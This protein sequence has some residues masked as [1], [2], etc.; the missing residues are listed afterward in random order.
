MY[1]I[2]NKNLRDCSPPFGATIK[3]LA[4]GM[5]LFLLLTFVGVIQASGSVLSQNN[6]VNL[7]LQ[8]AS[9]YD[10][11]NEIANQ[12]DLL[13]IFQETDELEGKKINVNLQAASFDQ[14]MKEVLKNSNLD[15]DLIENYI[16]VKQAV[17]KPDLKPAR[18][19]QSE[20]RTITGVVTSA[21][22][23]ASIP[24]VTIVVRGTNIGTTTD[25]DGNYQL[26]VPVE[27]SHLVFSFVGMV[28]QEIAI[29]NRTIINVVLEPASLDLG[30][31]IVVGY[32]TESRR[33]VSGSLGVVS[34][35]ELRD[36]PMKTIDGVLQGRSSGVFISQNSG[37]P[38]GANSVRIRGNSS[39]TA[40]NEPL[41]VIDGIPMTT[42][43]YGQIG[44]S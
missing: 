8:N 3:I 14:A 26:E 11:V 39:I 19:L 20:R 30:E 17:A 1:K 24:G 15:Y 9:V 6:L 32:G 27:S 21:D 33:L 42:G 36:M 40:G 5:K 41:Y 7:K 28:T 22:D 18:A 34:E 13:F 35:A 4:I 44:F 23:G 31:L 12:M 16:V 37:T 2:M 29:S 10:A 25:I 38:G 43:D